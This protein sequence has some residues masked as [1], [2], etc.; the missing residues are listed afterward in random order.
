M[1]DENPRWFTRSGMGP[2]PVAM[3]GAPVSFSADI[4]VSNPAGGNGLAVGETGV[5]DTSALQNGYRT[6][7][8]I[9]EIRMRCWAFITGSSLG[10]T[11]RAGLGS[12]AAAF[13]FRAGS[14]AFSARPMPMGLFAPNYNGR[15]LL[16][17]GA[18]GATPGRVGASVRWL[19]PRPLYMQPG[20]VITATVARSATAMLLSGLAPGG[21]DPFLNVGVTYVGRALPPGAKDPV[22]KNVPWVAFYQHDVA[23]LWSRAMLNGANPFQN[24]FTFPLVT[25]RL[26]GK[27][28]I[29]DPAGGG[30]FIERPNSVFQGMLPQATNKWV[31][32][33]IEDSAGYKVTRKFSAVGSVFDTERNAWTYN[34]A[35]AAR[36]QLDMQFQT[37]GATAIVPDA[38]CVGLIAHREEAS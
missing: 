29:A 14:Y 19:L 11:T 23:N 34:R 36:E 1:R 28:A 9:D 26:T 27:M 4:G 12:Y 5:F 37:N 30:N 7:Y 35:L 6:P 31:S 16:A 17:V 13:S 24:P 25:H 15:N 22:S 2:D 21:G 3:H 8:Y 32:C 20:D 10:T 18:T 38:F 33:Y